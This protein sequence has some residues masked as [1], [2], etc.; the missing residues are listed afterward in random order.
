MPSTRLQSRG[1]VAIMQGMSAQRERY[2]TRISKGK[3]K[4]YCVTKSAVRTGFS[5]EWSP[6]EKWTR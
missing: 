1:R 3:D 5:V 2:N 4:A 6:L